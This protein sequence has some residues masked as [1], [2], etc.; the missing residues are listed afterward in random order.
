MSSSLEKYRKILLSVTPLIR[1]NVPINA[2]TIE[3]AAKN[4]NLK[5]D[6][7]EIKDLKL[8]CRSLYRKIKEEKS[9]Y[10]KAVNEV[11]CSKNKTEPKKEDKK[12][13]EGEES[14]KK[15]KN[16]EDLT[17]KER[18]NEAK[19]FIKEI[20]MKNP[21]KVTSELIESTSI[22]YSLDTRHMKDC[23]KREIKESWREERRNTA[24]N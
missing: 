1:S 21:I 4:N 8:L 23:I 13:T 18:E 19:N 9:D 10:K 7:K 14:E 22:R 17:P 3:I 20:F 2:S 16:I 5:L 24:P 12:H 11:M 15:S 6:E